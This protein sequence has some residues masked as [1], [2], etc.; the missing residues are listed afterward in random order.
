M[1]W[2]AAYEPQRA[3]RTQRWKYIRRFGDRTTPVL[4]NCDDSPSKDLLIELGWGERT[5]AFEQLYDL[6]F[7]P[8]EAANLAGDPAHEGVRR[9]LSDRL[10]RWMV[11][12]SDPLLDGDPLP[13]PGAE[14]NEPDQ[15]SASEPTV[16]IA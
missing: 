13:P 7:D 3:I 2:H 12:T 4:V 9:E 5:I 6:A 1:T 11:E 15:I 16:V 8:N 14:I 10:Q